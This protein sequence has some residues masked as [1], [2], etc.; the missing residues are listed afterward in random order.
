MARPRNP[1]RDKAKEIWLNDK[2][3]KLKD[4]ANQLGETSNTIRKWK[5]QDKWEEDTEGSKPKKK[6]SP[7]KSSAPKG[8]KNALNNK[9]GAPKGNQN[10]MTHG[11]FS[12]FLPAET[13]EIVD[14]IDLRSP[15]DMLWDQIKMLYAAILRAQ[16][17]MYVTD[18]DDMIKEIRKG[19]AEFENDIDKDGKV[20][21]LP[22][23]SEVEYELQFAWDKQ[24]SFMNAQARSMGTL[25]NL[26]KNFLQISGQDDKRRLELEKMHQSL[27]VEKDMLDI[28]KQK[29]E[30]DKLR[31][32]GD[33]EEYEDDGFIAVLNGKTAE[34]WNDDDENKDS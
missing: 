27:V 26:I 20:V 18:Q 15:A 32:I 5:S 1:N 25:S 2:D 17:I 8:N 24:A 21:P 13:M 22:T 7:K 10:A 19:K 28:S 11:F 31:I 33:E 14:E 23:R 6:S 3:I 9:G 16:W 12:K 30:L 29:L 34:V 4:L